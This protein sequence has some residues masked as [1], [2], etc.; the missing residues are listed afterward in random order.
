MKTVH[1]KS[2]IIVLLAL[3]NVF[4]LSLLLLRAGQT[5]AAR[6]RTV[7]QL[8]RLY[9][10]DGIALSEAL[11]PFE[12][13]ELSASEPTRD[14]AG[15]AAF[16]EQLLGPCE[17]EELGGGVYR[18]AGRGGQCLFRS[19]GA[20]EAALERDVGD[21]EAFYDRFF[22]SVG[23]VALSSDINGGR[24]AAVGVR[25]L[26]DAQVFNAELTLTF[27]RGKLV[28]VSGYFVPAAEPGR[29]GG[30]MD[31]VTALVRFFDYRRGSGEVCTAVTDVRSGYILQS[32][33]SALQRLVPAWQIS[34]DV[35]RYYV[36][37]L[38]GDVTRDG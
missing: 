4:L 37:M 23:Y 30:E 24:G 8:V 22:S 19:S 11:V 32:S 14:H 20:V 27:A 16:A 28:A 15:E 1:L 9:A 38:T 6:E 13:P 17:R 18:Y 5:H 26:E 7:E 25:L 10:S 34:T 21:P 33:A 36:N 12:E 3:V 35:S 2:T 31:A 29:L